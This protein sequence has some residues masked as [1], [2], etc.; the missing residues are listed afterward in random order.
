MIEAP[1]AH[2][3]PPFPLLRFILPPL[4][5]H[6]DAETLTKPILYCVREAD[7]EFMERE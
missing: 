3:P 6:Y 4:L 2:S 7:K 5:S 1:S